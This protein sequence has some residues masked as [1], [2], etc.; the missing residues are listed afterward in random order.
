ML[1]KHLIT[2]YAVL[3]ALTAVF[4]SPEP[5]IAAPSS[6]A[7]GGTLVEPV[8]ITPF[9]KTRSPGRER[10][11]NAI[12]NNDQSK[13]LNFNKTG[14]GFTVTFDKAVV[15]NEIE[16][17]TANDDHG[18]DPIEV[19]I[20]GS[21]QSPQSG[22]SK[23]AD[24]PLTKIRD[25][26]A[27]YGNGFTNGTG[28]KYYRV[29]ITDVDNRRRANSFQFAEVDFYST[30]TPP[31]TPPAGA[32]GMPPTMAA[33]PAQAVVPVESSGGEVAELNVTI[34]ALQSQVATLSGQHVELQSQV[35]TLTTTNAQLQEPLNAKIAELNA[36]NA[37]LLAIQNAP[38][39]PSGGEVGQ[40]NARIDEL[41]RD[42]KYSYGN[43][44]IQRCNVN[45]LEER[46]V[47]QGDTNPF[48]GSRGPISSCY[49]E[50]DGISQVGNGKE[51][52]YYFGRK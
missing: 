32:T 37:R 14:S 9:G 5:A 50:N 8:D 35:A 3:F 18:R 52:S 6:P 30:G 48:H 47:K 16:F 31:M 19:E 15:V 27:P 22:F 12:D 40:L 23:I 25:R 2:F 41:K 51:Y 44:I 42:L 21:N 39:A 29:V 20:S 26:F 13:F 33:P 11:E 1:Q 28:Y 38:S 7:G 45:Y 4:Y 10:V 43:L 34:A 24:V 36:E 49:S 46:L 17:T